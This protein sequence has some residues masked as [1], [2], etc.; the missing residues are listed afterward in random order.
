ML[1]YFHCVVIIDL[2][3]DVNIAL[4]DD[5]PITPPG[6]VISIQIAT[7]DGKTVYKWFRNDGMECSP[8]FAEPEQALAALHA[9]LTDI[10]QRIAK[11]NEPEK[12][13]IIT[14]NRKIY[15]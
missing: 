9:G 5:V 11:A 15:R 8:T 3:R 13:K 4:V 2:V 10:L 14:R 6:T 1:E 12:P 7:Q